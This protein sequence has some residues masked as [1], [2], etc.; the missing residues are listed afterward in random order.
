MSKVIRIAAVV[1]LAALALFFFYEHEGVR[2]LAVAVLISFTVA[3][4]IGLA[5]NPDLFSA[6]ISP[7]NL[8]ASYITR[9]YLKDSTDSKFDQMSWV[10][11]KLFY[12]AGNFERVT[13]DKASPI[14]AVSLL[15]SLQLQ[16]DVIGK[17]GLNFSHLK[18]L[19]RRAV[20]LKEYREYLLTRASEHLPSI[21]NRTSD[22]MN[23]DDYVIGDDLRAVS[24]K[25][26]IDEIRKRNSEIAHIFTTTSQLS[27]QFINSLKEVMPRIEALNFYICS[28]LVMTH[29]SIQSLDVEYRNPAFCTSP[30]HLVDDGRGCIDVKADHV[31]RV[32]CILSALDSMIGMAGERRLIIHLFAKSYPGIKIRLL[33]K[34][35]FLQVQ[36][37]SLSYQNNLYR[38]GLDSDSSRFANEVSNDLRSLSADGFLTSISS[39]R[40]SIEELKQKSINELAISMLATG[41]SSVALIEMVPRILSKVPFTIARGF[42][43]DLCNR[44]CKLERIILAGSLLA[45]IP[46][47]GG[48]AH[49]SVGMFVI[50][51]GKTLLIKK[52]DSFYQGKYSIV[53]GHVENGEGPLEA[54]NR[55]S[56][57]ELGLA[58][59]T[60]KLACP[61][62]TLTDA[63]RHGAEEH[64]WFVF[65]C[66]IEGGS[67]VF[68]ESE[69][70]EVKWVDMSELP[71]WAPLLTDGAAGVLRKLG[72]I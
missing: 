48:V 51:D 12:K 19:A 53:A 21:K 16:K 7:R 71:A 69:I 15:L 28:P 64:I 1:M 25:N 49:T 43:D 52:A 34:S 58:P 24:D 10:V 70:S 40:S 32:I 14:V 62:F 9:R 5:K 8:V 57:E 46:I 45:Q 68:D 31:R 63:C 3:A 37:G 20:K 42:L 55:E 61:V 50:N 72:R 39:S 36:P 38:F 66:E 35:S 6:L 67:I 27:S 26:F 59:V 33:E 17:G 18:E 41:V 2:R 4:V 22:R 29:G 23:V 30:S 60:A 54:L 47:S 56:V 44:V 13:V 65:E 11:R